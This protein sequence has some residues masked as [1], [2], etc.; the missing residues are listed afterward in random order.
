MHLNANINQGP[1][2]SMELQIREY[3]E[4][5]PGPVQVYMKIRY[6]DNMYPARPTGFQVYVT[7][8]NGGEAYWE[9]TN[10]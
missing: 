3:A 1:M 2:K 8:G 7:Y 6:G 9:Y 5:H 4:E 10:P